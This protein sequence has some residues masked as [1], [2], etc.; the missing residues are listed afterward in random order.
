MARWFV[1]GAAG[2]LGQDL[3][4]VLEDA[5]HTVTRADLPG[6]DIL[7]PAQC[8][9]QVAGH[10]VVVNSAAYT[11]VD[12]AET[13]EARAFAVNAVGAANLARALHHLA[14]VLA[15]HAGGTGDEP[16]RHQ[17]ATTCWVRAYL[18]SVASFIGRHQASWSRYHSM[19][20]ASPSRKLP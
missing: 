3:C 2:M 4:A 15:Q 20:A 19:V 6:L 5:G 9:D 18:A 8:V 1:A 16:P 11:A 14:E 13:D 12:A 7:D 10:D 17:R